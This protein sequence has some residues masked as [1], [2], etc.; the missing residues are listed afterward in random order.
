M[1]GGWRA[2]IS[3]KSKASASTAK[4]SLFRKAAAQMLF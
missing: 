3:G 2:G 4:L 1:P